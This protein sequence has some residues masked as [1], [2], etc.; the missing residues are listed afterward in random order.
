METFEYI[1]MFF[2]RLEVFT[3]VRPTAK[4]MDIIIQIMVEVLSILGIALKKIKQGRIEKCW[5]RL[6]KRPDM[7]DA[8][9]KLD[10]LTQEEV[11]MAIAQILEGD[12][13]C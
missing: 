3:E 13:Y 7:E 6:F 4:M 2:R 5:N 1:E 8:L 9:E 10:N 11:R 12:A